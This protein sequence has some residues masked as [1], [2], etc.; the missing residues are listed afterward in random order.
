[1]KILKNTKQKKEKNGE[2][3]VKLCEN[4]V[5]VKVK[6]VLRMVNKIKIKTMLVTWR[7]PQFSRKSLTNFIK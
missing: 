5:K 3:R 2:N 6:I 7:K 1:L 4:V